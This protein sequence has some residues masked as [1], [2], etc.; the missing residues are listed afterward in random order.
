MYQEE[1]VEEAISEKHS[2]SGTSVSIFTSEEGDVMDDEVYEEQMRKRQRHAS[3]F[4]KFV[5]KSNRRITIKQPA[6]L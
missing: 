2:Y 3:T 6:L 1:E 4:T 5:D